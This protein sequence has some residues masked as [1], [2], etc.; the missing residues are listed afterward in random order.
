MSRLSTLGRSKGNEMD[1][2][3]KTSGGSIGLGMALGVALGAGVGAAL[4]NVA[5]G[6]GVGVAIGVAMGSGIELLRNA[7]RSESS[8]ADK[9]DA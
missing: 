1:A 9:E 8:A 6:T 5:I 2:K 7:S 4:D 3:K